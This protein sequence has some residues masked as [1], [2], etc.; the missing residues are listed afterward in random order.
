MTMNKADLTLEKYNMSLEQPWSEDIMDSE[1]WE[2]VDDIL[3]TPNT[4]YAL[5]PDDEALADM[6]ALDLIADSENDQPDQD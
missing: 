4:Y 6:A 3:S 1:C 5:N 2:W